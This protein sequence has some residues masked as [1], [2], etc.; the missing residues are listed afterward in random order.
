M[1]LCVLLKSCPTRQ[2]RDFP[3]LLLILTLTQQPPTIELRSRMVITHSVRIIPK[4]Y[5]ISGPITLKG[6]DLTVDFQGATLQGIAREADP[7]QARD[8]AIVVAG[9]RNVRIV[10][11][12]VRGYKVGILARGTRGLALIGNDL[13]YNWKPRLFSLVEHESLVDWLSFHHNERDEWLRFG[14]AIYLADVTGGAVRDNTVEQGM[15]GLLL[16]RSNGMAIRDNTFSFNSGLGIGLYRSSD[17]T[18]IHNRVDY[19]VRGYSHRFYSRGQDSAGLLI[20]EQSCRNIVADNSLTHGGDGVFLWAGQTTMDS[21]SGGA[22][23]NLFYGNDV[24]YATA[25][26]IEA[27]FSRNRIIGNRAWG[28]E[29]GVGGGYSYQTEIVGNDFRGNRT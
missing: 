1:R 18:I 3:M 21:G 9:G 4:T 15:N 19:D 20:Y 7:D 25:N 28:S 8:T 13:S 23:E 24:S 26:G 29:Y 14:A 2:D 10:H 6:D 11:A 12:R 5:R 27:T 17:D 16:V 22:N